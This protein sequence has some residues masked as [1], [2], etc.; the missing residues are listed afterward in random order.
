MSGLRGVIHCRDVPPP[1]SVALLKPRCHPEAIAKGH[2]F[3]VFKGAPRS[4]KRK[5]VETFVLEL[6][7]Y[8]H[9]WSLARVDE[10]KP[11]P[12]AAEVDDE[13]LALLRSARQEAGGRC[14]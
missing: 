5:V 6:D 4:G 12:T 1:Y 14:G 9:A 10:A 13:I 7:A 8:E 3:G 2:R 11:E